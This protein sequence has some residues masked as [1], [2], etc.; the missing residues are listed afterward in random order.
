MNSS[1]FNFW[2]GIF[3]FLF[4]IAIMHR[5]LIPEK[6]WTGNKTFPSKG[7]FSW[8]Y[9]SSSRSWTTG[10][11]GIAYVHFCHE[12]IDLWCVGDVF[13]VG[14]LVWFFFFPL[15]RMLKHWVRLHRGSASMETLKA[16]LVEALSSTTLS[17]L[18]LEGGWTTW[19]L[20]VPSNPSCSM[21]LFFL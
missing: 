4:S 7:F 18:L 12:L 16:W 11:E 5:S 1:S 17:A 2:A 20:E 13:L 15:C 9:A 19:C 14:C 21:I 8:F 6:L 3:I 10:T